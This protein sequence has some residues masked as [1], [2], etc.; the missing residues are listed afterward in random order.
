MPDQTLETTCCIV[1]GGPAGIMLGYLLAR[2]GVDVI[3]LEKHDDFFRDFRGDTV[4][5]STL[6]RSYELGLL[7]EFL[8]VPHQKL[9]S[10]GAASAATPV[11][12]WPTSATCRTPASSSRSCRNGIFSTSSPGRPSSF[13]HFNFEWSTKPCDLIRA[14]K[15][16]LPA[17]KRRT[18]TVLYRFSPTS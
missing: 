5:P 7:D 15:S 8:K 17:C 4:H 12:R 3:V 1:G 2:A 18:R 13:R 16:H 10:V 14:G 6:E 9:T 11:S